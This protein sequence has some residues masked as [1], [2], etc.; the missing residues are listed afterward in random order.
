ME[1]KSRET[2]QETLMVVQMAV[3]RKWAHSKVIETVLI[4]YCC[5]KKL[6]QT[7]AKQTC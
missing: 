5:H 7:V 4:S 1:K 6:A 2:R 3:K